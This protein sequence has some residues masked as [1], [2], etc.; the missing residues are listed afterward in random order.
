MKKWLRLILWVGLIAYL[1]VALGFVADRRMDAVCEKLHIVIRD[2]SVNQ[3]IT[4]EE[5]LDL[6]LENQKELLGQK[7]YKINKGEIEDLVSNHSFV[8]NSEIYSTIDGRLNIELEQRKP[9][10]R[11]V[12]GKRESYYIDNEAVIFPLS[13]NYSSRVLLANGYI[14]EPFDWFKN[15]KLKPDELTLNR[16]SRVIYDLY[17]LSEYIYNNELWRAQFAQIYVNSKYEFELI[18][19]VGAHVIYFG[20]ISDYQEKFRKLEAMYVHGFS[21][22]GWNQYEIINLKFKNQVVCS[23]R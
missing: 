11:I 14:F 22:T 12:N 13:K 2:S 1:V 18:P 3:F 16:R 4:K 23:K 17:T 8:K 21:N 5:I 10:L 19:R 20:D 6:V 15:R 7:F 9:I